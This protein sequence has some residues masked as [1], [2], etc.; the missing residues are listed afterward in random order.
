MYL[1]AT[2]W[3]LKKLYPQYV[4]NKSRQEKA[5]Y[6]TFDD[7]PHPI[8]TPWV[9]ELLQAY[10]AKA[11]FFCIGKNV[12]KYPEIYHQILQQGHTV[13]NHTQN[14]LNG[15]KTKPTK[16]LQDIAEAGTHIKSNFFRPP[17]G[18]ITKLQ[19]AA[20]FKEQQSFSEKPQVIMWDVLSGDFDTTL[21]PVSCSKKVLKHGRNGSIIVFHDSDK[22][23]PRLEYSLPKVLEHFKGMGFV[24]KAL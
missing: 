12:V 6:L 19:A 7:G 20:L 2:P 5:L 18:R 17:Y 11:S 1:A 13:G 24:F 16:Y 8:I 23:W 10:R 3:W 4:W 22:A 14:H 15:W 21:T 9:L